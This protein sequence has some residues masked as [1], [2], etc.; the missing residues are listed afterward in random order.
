[1]KFWYKSK[2][3]W[4]GILEITIAILGAVAT[5]I[6]VGNYTEPA[7]ILFASGVLMILLRYMTDTG[8]ML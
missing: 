2:T 8:I 3:V 6:E 4:I 1:M 7:C 5:F